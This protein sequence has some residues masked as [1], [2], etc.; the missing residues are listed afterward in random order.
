MRQDIHKKPSRP[1]GGQSKSIV[2][3]GDAQRME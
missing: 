1:P 3:R 2:G